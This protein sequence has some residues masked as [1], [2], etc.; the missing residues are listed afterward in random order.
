ME[1]LFT[2]IDGPRLISCGFAIKERLKSNKGKVTIN[3]GA[4]SEIRINEKAGTAIVSWAVKSDTPSAPFKFDAA[5]EALFK[6]QK[7]PMQSEVIQ[8]GQ[9]EVGPIL[10][11]ALRD[12]VSELTKKAGLPP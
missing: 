12:F 2:I 4:L 11:V 3:C 7:R 5:F 9:Q 6:M 1:K 10:F 8:A